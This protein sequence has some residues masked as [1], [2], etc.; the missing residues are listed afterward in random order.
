MPA[1][2]S[3]IVFV[4]T[5]IKEGGNSQKLI[6]FIRGKAMSG[7]LII[8]GSDQFPKPPIGIGIAK[9]KITN[10]WL[11]TVTSAEACHDL[12]GRDFKL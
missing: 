8:R 11:V 5:N 7:A 10:A 2:C 3:A 4:I 1:P 6:L 12:C 9:K